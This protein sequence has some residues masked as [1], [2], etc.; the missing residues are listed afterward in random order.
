MRGA[1]T[2]RSLLERRLTRRAALARASGLAAASWAVG[3]AWSDEP[4][5]GG[6]GFERLAGSKDDRVVVPRGYH[7]VPVLRWGDPLAPDA[8]SL[9]VER[10]ADGLLL[11]AGAAAAQARQFG[12]NCD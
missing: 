12:Y 6:L 9:A 5:A 11:E 3:V 7:A 8:P 4:H 10:V 2:L 1:D